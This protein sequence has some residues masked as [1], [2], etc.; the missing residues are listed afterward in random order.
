MAEPSETNQNDPFLVVLSS[1]ETGARALLSALAQ[2]RQISPERAAILKY[3]IDRVK[4]L[5]TLCEQ[6]LLVSSTP[7]V[8]EIGADEKE[9]PRLQLEGRNS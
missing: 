3:G 7:S 6:T 8:V 5:L 4:V 2:T 9:L 1:A